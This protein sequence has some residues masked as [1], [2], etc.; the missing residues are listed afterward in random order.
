MFML[1]LL[2]SL[3]FKVNTVFE[4][5]L[6]DD[7]ATL[8]FSDSLM[9]QN[10]VKLPL[11]GDWLNV[12]GDYLLVLKKDTVYFFNPYSLKIDKKEPVQ[13]KGI[14]R[15]YTDKRGR[16][17]FVSGENAFL[18][19]GRR[20]R[21]EQISDTQNIV[22]GRVINAS[23]SSPASLHGHLFYLV[24]GRVY[25]NTSLDTVPA[26]AIKDTSDVLSS[27]L[28]RGVIY[29]RDGR[30]II[31][32]KVAFSNLPHGIAMLRNDTVF[33]YNLSDTVYIFSYPGF[34]LKGC[35]DKK[36][37]PFDYLYSDYDG[38]VYFHGKE[39]YKSR[40]FVAPT[41]LDIDGDG[42]KD[43]I[44]GRMDGSFAL[45]KKI[46]GKY[47]EWM[48]YSPPFPLYK[49]YLSKEGIPMLYLTAP[50]QSPYRTLL[51]TVNP[52][53][54]DE[55]LYVILHASPEFND[56]LIKNGISQLW[57]NV[58]DIYLAA[59]RLKYVSLIELPDGKTT[60]LLNGEDTVPDE[61]YYR[62]VVFPRVLYEFPEENLFRSYFMNDHMYGKSVLEVVE[63]D[64]S[65]MD[66][67]RDFYRWAKSF[68]HFGYMTNDLSPI[69]IYKKA[70]GSCGEHSI[71]SAALLK[72]ILIPSYVAI[73]MGEDHQWNELYNGKRWVHFDLTQPEKKAIDNPHASSEGMGHKEVSTVVGA[74]PEGGYFAITHHGYT[75]TGRINISVVDRNNEPV[76]FA[77]VVLVSHWA[78]RQ[79][80]SFFKFTDKE[81][82]V[83]FDAGHEK[84]GYSVYVYSPYGTG[85]AYNFMVKEGDT[86]D[87]PVRVGG[88]I[89][90]T[91]GKKHNAKF[92]V[93]LKNFRTGESM[94]VLM[95]GYA[96]EK[97]NSFSNPYSNAI[98]E[99][100]KQDTLYAKDI[101]PSIHV[102]LRKDT[103]KNGN[104]LVF[105]IKT[106]DNLGVKAVT[107]YISGKVKK[108]F[109]LKKLNGEDT[110]YLNS[111]SV[112][113]SGNYIVTFRAQDFGGNVDS[114][115]FNIFLAPTS[116]FVNQ[117][118]G[119]DI[120]G[121]NSGG[122]NY[123]FQV[124]DTVPYLYIHTHGKTER[125]DIDLFFKRGGK[126][127]AKSTSPTSDETV[128]IHPLTPGRYTVTVQGWYVPRGKGLFDIKIDK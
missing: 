88:V 47:Q 106:T 52:L 61:I 107:A 39:I 79:S 117:F 78:K 16:L 65:V 30:V 41:L 26:I 128:Y 64:T 28:K 124:K 7:T 20:L 58:F 70:Y 105:D 99:I 109:T 84:N 31:N 3:E 57:E 43:V 67:V 21:V 56:S 53:Y 37:S 18:N 11:S 24:G 23:F 108:R 125:M 112:M 80:I 1:V 36:Y 101:P 81:G 103:L 48:S 32:G 68:M 82:R 59:R 35:V 120:T 116:V 19:S 38:R 89:N 119:Q 8:N 121:T 14:Q 77:L 44:V 27:Y 63:K 50:E 46:N 96:L 10:Y 126:V 9:V 118:I 93:F 40:Y 17:L 111:G 95:P 55:I 110:L 60:L 12:K 66:A 34:T 15:I 49:R 100:Q 54:R 83:Y 42:K 51:D 91:R 5:T 85:G 45:L 92:L 123:S 94:P 75:E 113:P 25:L 98:M 102:T 4:R 74:I 97:G 87:L 86:T 6:P 72:T 122:W 115:S 33:V 13:Y 29:T 69:T 76:P 71:M 22:Q 73:D 62:F 104:P 114:T 90:E 2:L 127:I